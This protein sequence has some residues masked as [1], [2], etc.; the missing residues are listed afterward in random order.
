MV[1]VE[2]RG[3]LD[4]AGYK[5]LKQFLEANA[6]HIE[7]HEREMYL[8]FDYP[9]YD[10]DPI[11]REVDIRLRNTNGFCEIMM[12]TKAAEGNTARHEVSL[13]LQVHD[14]ATAKE[15]AKGF[16]CKTALK[17]HREKEMYEYNGIEWSL[18]KTPPKDYYYYEA[19]KAVEPES[20]LESVRQEL[21]MAAKDLQLEVLDTN[22]MRE[23]IY[24]LDK[25]VN[26]IIEL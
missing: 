1:E 9:G 22:A 12:K 10:E 21:V 6:R 13:P 18:V 17:M 11:T 25:E 23:F 24:F 8:L 14:L 26:E 7:S 16:G 5:K 4:E 3:R 15:I 20:D 2:I 19:E